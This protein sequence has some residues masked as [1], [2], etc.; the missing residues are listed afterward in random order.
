MLASL[1][2]LV[3]AAA[4]LVAVGVEGA[5]QLP[6]V[7]AAEQQARTVVAHAPLSAAAHA[8]A[9]AS[10]ADDGMGAAMEPVVTEAALDAE[11]AELA[12]ERAMLEVAQEEHPMRR[13]SSPFLHELRAKAQADAEAEADATA[14]AAVDD[15]MARV[16]GA[17][18][19]REI[20]ERLRP[21]LQPATPTQQLARDVPPLPELV[22][23]A[24][25]RQLRT[26]HMKHVMEMKYKKQHAAEMA[27]RMAAEAEAD[28][29]SEAEA[30]SE[31]ES[32]AAKVSAT[33]SPTV[34]K[35]GEDQRSYR[36]VTLSNGLRAV[37]VSDPNTTKSAAAIDVGNGYLSDPA[38]LP[39]LAHFLEHMLFLGTEKYPSES[40]Y[41][42]FI[43]SHGG[44]SNAYTVRYK[45]LPGRRTGDTTSNQ[46]ALP[47]P[48]RAARTSPSCAV[49]DVPD[50]AVYVPTPRRWRT[51][52][53]TSISFR[54]TLPARWT[55][56]L[57]SSSRRF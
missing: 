35:S 14:A 20:R 3:L 25:Q 6:S 45:H 27:A 54:L 28:S 31:S 11:L 19:A 9:V 24:K 57:S 42:D 15:L 47:V 36:F 52:T 29:E 49:A 13:T 4:L 53:T 7:G 10:G 51:P 44:F 48:L 37:L 5:M 43:E 40:A 18:S 8:A 17:E 41:A 33:A 2:L 38:E 30:E 21:Y 26:Q 55:A 56:S 1:S 22:S 39:G 16:E 50:F 46:C 34:T 32:G 12:A 23:F